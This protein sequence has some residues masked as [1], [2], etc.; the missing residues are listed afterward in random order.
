MTKTGAGLNPFETSRISA[1][2]A[3][4]S[5]LYYYL[6]IIFICILR[7]CIANFA[8]IRIFVVSVAH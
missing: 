5:D 1:L 3:F 8:M 6:R 2:H 4:P 7:P